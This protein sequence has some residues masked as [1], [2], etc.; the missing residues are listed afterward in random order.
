MTYKLFNTLFLCTCISTL[1]FS[2]GPLDG[3]MKGKGILDL[4]P[5]ISFNS[6][7]TFIGAEQQSFDLGY[8]GT[9]V[10]MFAEYGI[11]SKLDVV[12]TAAYVFTSTQSGLQDGGVYLKYRPVYAS[13]GPAGKLGVLFGGGL[14]F[15]LSD[16]E[17]TTSGALG[18]KAVVLPGRLILQ[19]DS[20]IGLFVNVTGGYNWRLD[21]L[22]ED[23]IA[24]VRQERPEFMPMEPPN[25]STFLLRVGLPKAP[26][27]PRCLGRMAKHFRWLRLCGECS[28]SGAGIWS[29]LYPIR[30]YLLLF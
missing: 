20:P 23:D 8:K 27:L 10:S 6:A 18:Q 17:P 19:W 11:S 28:G 3:Y 7:N 13:L 14:G 30:R 16:Y 5:S 22:Q 24:V 2:Q 9:L 12:A 21:Q 15:P 1:T 26:V 29:L 4:A 25:Y